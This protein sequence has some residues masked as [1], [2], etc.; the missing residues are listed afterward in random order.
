MLL[1]FWLATAPSKPCW[2]ALL[3]FQPHHS[4]SSPAKTPDL[5]TNPPQRRQPTSK[6]RIYHLE[7]HVRIHDR[8]PPKLL[9]PE[10]EACADAPWV[11]LPTRSTRTPSLSSLQHS[12]TIL[13][14]FQVKNLSLSWSSSWVQRDELQTRSPYRITWPRTQTRYSGFQSSARVKRW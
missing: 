3:H 12:G 6:P 10:S 14:S 8:R 9:L 13:A 7:P 11:P 2:G 1:N 5:P 4:K